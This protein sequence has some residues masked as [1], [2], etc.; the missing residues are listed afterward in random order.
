MHH[1]LRPKEILSKVFNFDLIL[2][3][4]NR[5]SISC[6]NKENELLITFVQLL[7]THLEPSKIKLSHFC[8]KGKLLSYIMVESVKQ[9][10]FIWESFLDHR[11][12]QQLFKRPNYH[13]RND[14]KTGNFPYCF[15][16]AFSTRILKKIFV[17][18]SKPQLLF[19][20]QKRLF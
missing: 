15:R 12:S 14:P 13:L 16:L 10:V 7:K 2:F 8:K 3:L 18:S 1:F 19:I 17:I 9:V 4:Q 6:Y 5:I 20:F 11:E